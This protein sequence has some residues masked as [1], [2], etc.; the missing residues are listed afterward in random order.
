MKKIIAVLLALTV[1]F[2]FAACGGK[3]TPTDANTASDAEQAAYTDAVEVLTTIFAAYEEEN[4]F[5]VNGGDAENMSF[6]APAK[7]DIAKADEL[8]NNFA[9]PASQAENIENAAT[10]VHGMMTNNFS[11]AAYI[12]KSDA[13]AKAFA[14]EFTAGLSG[15]QWLCGLPEKYVVISAGNCVI[16]AFGLAE[17]L[18][19]FE[20]TATT[21][22]ENAQVLASGEI[23]E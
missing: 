22:L 20:T 16:T 9:L 8:A 3:K 4:K 14:D 18:G 23:T 15:R 21:V 17:L 5:P 13:D 6:E 12:L 2:A 7:Y 1:L 10:A 19:N 11:G